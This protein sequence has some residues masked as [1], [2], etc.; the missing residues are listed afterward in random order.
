[1]YIHSHVIGRLIRFKN[2]N[3]NIKINEGATTATTTAAST[4]RSVD[5]VKLDLTSATAA[6][7]NNT[8]NANKQLEAALSLKS[9]NNTTTNA[10]DGVHTSGSGHR[11]RRQWCDVRSINRKA[12][13]RPLPCLFAFTLLISATGSYYSLVAP[14]LLRLIENFYHWSAIIVL[15]SIL[16]LLVLVNFIIATLI[17][18][19]RFP[20]FVIA[21][22][23]PNF[24]DDTKS[25]LYKTILIKQTTVK[26]KW[27]SVRLILTRNCC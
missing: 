2:H 8:I 19:G 21:P 17:D 10:Y 1:M 9:L 5:Q 12:I 23:D 22:D 3:K 13:K 4:V 18:P 7:E 14:E 27:C 20:K 26:I 24:S 6:E 11:K 16:F 15:Q 25:P